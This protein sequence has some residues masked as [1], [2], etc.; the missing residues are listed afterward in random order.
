MGHFLG[1]DMNK[2]IAYYLNLPY[3]IEVTHG[4]L[5]EKNQEYWFASVQELPGCMTEAESFAE[6]EGMIQDAIA[7]WVED[8]LADG[9][10]IPEPRAA[11]AYGG[12]LIATLPRTLHR[13]MAKAAEKEGVTL[14]AFV[15]MAIAH[16]VERKLAET[17]PG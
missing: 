6:L 13:D 1:N 14:N 3:T 17:S 8:A 7:S 9:D 10:P 11:D 12:K 5:A 4:V 16:S 2:D 15:N